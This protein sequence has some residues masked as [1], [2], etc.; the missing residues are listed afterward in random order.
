MLDPNSASDA[1]VW[2]AYSLVEA[3]RL[4]KIPCYTNWAAR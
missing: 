2:M 1:D 3:G 4:W